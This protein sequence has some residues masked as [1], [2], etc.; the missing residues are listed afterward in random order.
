[1][2]PNNKYTIFSGKVNKG[3]DFR[4]YDIIYHD[5]PE[6]FQSMSHN[7]ETG[8]KAEGRG[9]RR[10]PLTGEGEHRKGEAMFTKS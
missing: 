6:I 9:K 4:R 8:E 7:G 3:A 1:M 2:R 10:K 5:M